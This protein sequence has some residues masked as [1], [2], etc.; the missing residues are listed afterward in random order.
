M[1]AKMEHIIRVNRSKTNIAVLKCAINATSLHETHTA[2]TLFPLTDFAK[3]IY[4]DLCALAKD[5]A[6][7][8]EELNMLE[9]SNDFAPM[10]EESEV[11]K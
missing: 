4:D 9:P 2:D 5:I 10:D 8:E 6:V 7:L 3:S 1:A 11:E